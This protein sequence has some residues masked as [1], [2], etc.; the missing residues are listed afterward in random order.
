MFRGAC[1]SRGDE[2]AGFIL[3]VLRETG[4]GLGDGRRGTGREGSR[5]SRGPLKTKNNL[6]KER[7]MKKNDEK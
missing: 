4:V 3:D 5:K 1:A 7:K 6:K 2:W